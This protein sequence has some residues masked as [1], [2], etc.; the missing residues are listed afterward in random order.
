MRGQRRS[1]ALATVLVIGLGFAPVAANAPTPVG[2]AAA[3]L[4]RVAIAPGGAAQMR[5]AVLRQHLALADRVETGARSQLQI[6]LLDR[7]SFT[8][9]AN[10]RLTIDRFVYDPATGRSLGASVAKGAFRFI[11]GRPSRGGSSTIATPVASIGIRGTIV[12]GVIGADA[13]A[14][15]NGERAV[16]GGRNPDPETATLIVLRGPGRNAQGNALPGAISVSAGGKTV[17]LERPLLAVFVPRAGAQPIGPFAMSL[18]G[19][20]RV[21]G[22]IFPSLA[23]WRLANAPAARSPDPVPA[24]QQPRR[25]RP[26]MVGDPTGG[27]PPGDPGPGGMVPS[28]GFGVPAMP[29]MPRD[30]AHRPAQSPPARSAATR[31]EPAPA[32]EPAPAGDPPE[33]QA[34]APQAPE[35]APAAPPPRQA[36]PPPQDIAPSPPPPPGAPQQSIPPVKRAAPPPPP[37]GQSA[38]PTSVAPQPGKQSQTATGKP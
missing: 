10:A 6:L 35:P 16:G 22:L 29:N 33:T 1:A 7:S 9:G 2:I 5:P 19:L 20:T 14:I 12:D 21:Q 30:S 23:Q 28:Y 4:N 15:A 37:A 11:S 18:P 31:Q 34:A 26:V 38:S 8:V 25:L 32:T 36:A 3:V 27:N 13:I 17:M 24:A